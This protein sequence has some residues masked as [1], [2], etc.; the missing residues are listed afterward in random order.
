MPRINQRDK[1]RERERERETERGVTFENSEIKESEEGVPP[2]IFE[3]FSPQ[4]L[5]TH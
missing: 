5:D 3:F 4:K 1:E 2:K